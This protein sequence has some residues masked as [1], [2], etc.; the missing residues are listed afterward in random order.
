[1]NNSSPVSPDASN[2]VSRRH[3]LKQSSAVAAGAALTQ[4]P[5]VVTTHAAP[6]T[7]IRIGLIGCGGRGTG[8]VANAIGAATD[9]V[10]PQAGYHTE[11]ISKNGAAASSNVELF[12]LADVFPDRLN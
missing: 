3:F 12:A 9:V 2:S 5:F 8:A 4:F 1:M 10:Y 7:R 6:D 11:N